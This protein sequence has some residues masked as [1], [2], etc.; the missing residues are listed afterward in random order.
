[1]QKLSVH[2]LRKLISEEVETVD[3]DVNA[4]EDVWG[5]D[6]TGEDGNLA[7]S[8]DHSKVGGA[9]EVTRHPEMLPN[10]TPVLHNENN[11]KIQVYRG[12]N[13]VGRSHRVPIII[14]E[15][16]YDAVVT[17]NEP[18]ARS[19]IEEHL[20]RAV[21]GWYDYEWRGYNG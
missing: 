20:D 19:I 15:L 11:S 2:E 16:Y 9:P 12:T 10:A 3:D 4:I 1:M 18:L 7:L 13:D 17:G 21:P 5:G 8:L 14:L 6:I